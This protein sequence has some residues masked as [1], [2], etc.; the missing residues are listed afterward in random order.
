MAVELKKGAEDFDRWLSDYQSLEAASQ[1]Q[2]VLQVNKFLKKHP[3]FFS[4]PIEAKLD[5]IARFV[6]DSDSPRCYHR[7]YALKHWL[8]SLG[9]T[10][11]AAKLKPALKRIRPKPRRYTIRSL[12]EGQVM[13]TVE[14]VS[15]DQNLKTIIMIAYDTALRIS[16]ILD[17]KA[18]NLN[19]DKKA[20]LYYLTA[21][22]KRGKITTKYIEPITAKNI[23]SLGI[24]KGYLFM[25]TDKDRK[26]RRLSYYK[27]WSR[28]KNLTRKSL[29]FDFGISF[30]WF[31]SSRAIEIMKEY[32]II[33]AQRMLDHS[34]VAVTE[35]YVS[36][37]GIDS[38]NI[39]KKE[40]K[41]KVMH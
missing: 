39:I 32:D 22:I 34:S 9:E 31:R 20:G 29:G 4:M 14:A 24:S 13:K 27:A 6:N 2:Y 18:E 12:T 33:T 36:E 23:K 35:R 19:Y 28:L 17:L 3:D 38:R 40:R 37:A 15:G 1:R 7:K 41:W 25:E 30:H 26:S 5:L 11:L 10:S 21:R 16:S 8:K